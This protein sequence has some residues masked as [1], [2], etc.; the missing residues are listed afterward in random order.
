MSP[1]QARLE[2]LRIRCGKGFPLDAPQSRR[3]L[4]VAIA[5]ASVKH[6]PAALREALEE[7]TAP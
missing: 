6:P 1:A 3:V 5:A 2:A 7:L 4:A